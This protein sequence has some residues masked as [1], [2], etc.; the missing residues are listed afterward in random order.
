MWVPH[1]VKTIQL[2]FLRAV[3]RVTVFRRRKKLPDEV[4]QKMRESLI[5]R[6]KDPEFR[7][8]NLLGHQRYLASLKT[9]SVCQTCGVQF[10][11]PKVDVRKFCST[12][13]SNRREKK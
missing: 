9:M 3:F 5:A 8:R 11:H 2:R 12:K 7:S 1:S 4:V 10:S 13:C 6:W